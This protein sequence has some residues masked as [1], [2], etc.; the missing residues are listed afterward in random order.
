MTAE[1]IRTGMSFTLGACLVALGVLVVDAAFRTHFFN[2]SLLFGLVVG[3]WTTIY[4]TSR[5]T[6]NQRT[7]SL[8]E[9]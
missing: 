4:L 2:G 5:K 3:G 7:E 9:C 6:K 1:M 8:C